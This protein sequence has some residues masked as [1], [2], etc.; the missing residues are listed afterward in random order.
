MKDKSFA[1]V[2]ITSIFSVFVIML[3]LSGVIKNP[4]QGTIKVDCLVL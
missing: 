3:F 2:I 1:P 4:E